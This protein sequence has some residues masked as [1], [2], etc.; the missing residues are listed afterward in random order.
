LYAAHA[1][2]NNYANIRLSEAERATDARPIR[3]LETRLSEDESIVTLPPKFLV[4]MSSQQT[5]LIATH[6]ELT[7]VQEFLQFEA[8][9]SPGC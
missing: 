1:C 9:K 8:R 2:L 4:K 6:R 5:E 7:D 3:E